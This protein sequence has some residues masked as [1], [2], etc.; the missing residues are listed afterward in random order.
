MQLTISIPKALYERAQRKLAAEGKTVAESVREYLMRL[1]AEQEQLEA[2][3]A[4]L[5]RTAGCGR[6]P[7][8]WKFNRDECYEDRLKW[9]RDPVA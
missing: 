5:R 2:D 6:S 1:G 9:P 7:E 8:G 4:F 3:I